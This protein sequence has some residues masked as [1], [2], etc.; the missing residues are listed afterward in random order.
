MIDYYAQ[1]N[2]FRIVEVLVK[3]QTP[4]DINIFNKLQKCLQDPKKTVA[5]NLFAHIVRKVSSNRQTNKIP[6]NNNNIQIYKHTF[7]HY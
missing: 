2:S 1:T 5:L 4:H 6:L 7:S 3:V